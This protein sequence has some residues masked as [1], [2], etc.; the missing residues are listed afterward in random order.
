M[1]RHHLIG[2]Y[3]PWRQI[4]RM[5][6]QG[7]WSL[8]GHGMGSEGGYPSS[9]AV[10]ALNPRMGSPDAPV[11]CAHPFQSVDVHWMRPGCAETPLVL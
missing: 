6:S 10:V 9:S 5:G 4:K 1:V 8:P 3:F 11:E 2:S 7:F